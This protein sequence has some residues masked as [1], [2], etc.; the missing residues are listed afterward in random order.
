MKVCSQRYFILCSHRRAASVSVGDSGSHRRARRPARALR[1]PASGH[2]PPCR[3]RRP[4][5]LREQNR[6]LHLRDV[7]LL[8]SQFAQFARKR[9]S[10]RQ[11]W[12]RTAQTTNIYQCFLVSLQ[13]GP[14]KNKLGVPAN[15]FCLQGPQPTPPLNYTPRK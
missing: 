11:L 9:G 4:C 1:P 3:S 13:G 15:F 6:T 2:S 12:K 10:L 14:A 7:S 8:Q 5:Y